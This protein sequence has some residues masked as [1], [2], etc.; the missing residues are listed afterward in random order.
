MGRVRIPSPHRRRILV[1]G[2][3]GRQFENLASEHFDR[4]S[5]RHFLSAPFHPGYNA[6]SLCNEPCSLEVEPGMPLE[7]F[8]EVLTHHAGGAENAYFDSRL[9]NCL[10]IR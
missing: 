5:A 9:H 8:D 3:K 7:E 1:I 2:K 4:M 6:M 10:T